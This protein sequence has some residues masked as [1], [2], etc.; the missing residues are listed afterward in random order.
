MKDRTKTI[1]GWLLV[2][3]PIP[4]LCIALGLYAAYAFTVASAIP[5]ADT[6]A[7]NMSIVF[8][9]IGVL[10][11]CSVFF[12]MPLGL[13][14]LLSRTPE[15]I[16][17]K[18]ITETEVEYRSAAAF[19]KVT[20]GCLI[21]FSLAASADVIRQSA[22][23]GYL[24][25]MT[26]TEAAPALAFPA[27]LNHVDLVIATFFVLSAFSVLRWKFLAYRNATLQNTTFRHTHHMA[28]LSYF[29]P[30]L[31]L[32]VPYQAMKDLAAHHRADTATRMLWIW[33]FFFLLAQIA[34]TIAPSESNITTV[35]T[36]TWRITATLVWDASLILSAVALIIIVLDITREQERSFGKR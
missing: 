29:I 20:V 18:T 16:D 12:G 19:A 23:L 4:S 7:M 11:L 15:N 13:Y 36:D 3:S 34:I 27:A 35:A 1:A 17:P 24:N 8:G 6:S 32:Y 22:L 5:D 28:S 26:L 10:G 31:N 21:A 2:I 14:F 33:W 9:I 30:F 25:T